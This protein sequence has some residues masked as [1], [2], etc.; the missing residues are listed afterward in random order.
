[1]E[2]RVVLEKSTHTHEMEGAEVVK[3]FGNGI[4]Q[5][6][7]EKGIVTHGE[8]GTIKTESPDVIKYVQQE[9]N[10]ITKAMMNAFD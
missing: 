7:V 1:M 4:L 5:L 8:H 10:P 6:K 3:D 9:V 2:K